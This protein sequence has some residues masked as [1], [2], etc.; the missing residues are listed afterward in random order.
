VLRR[1]LELD[2]GLFERQCG[3]IVQS[4]IILMDLLWLLVR[5]NLSVMR[6]QPLP[7]LYQ[8]GVKYK[9]EG[10][11]EKFQYALAVIRDGGAD[12]ED[13]AAW[14]V[15][16]VMHYGGFAGFRIDRFEPSP[17]NPEKTYHIRV[18]HLIPTA[19]GWAHGPVE[20]PSEIL[21]MRAPRRKS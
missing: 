4:E 14:R 18:Q 19:S 5:R 1:K 3:S 21:G 10:R 20:D 2:I 17:L 13:L 6:C 7:L 12:C 15:A 11:V 9:P 16:E 8:A